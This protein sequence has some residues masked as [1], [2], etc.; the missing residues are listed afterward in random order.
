MKNSQQ[1]SRWKRSKAYAA[2][3]PKEPPES[4]S[5]KYPP[6]SST[7][8][9]SQGNRNEIN[10]ERDAGVPR[11]SV[12]ER[13]QT[14]HQLPQIQIRQQDQPQPADE[15][16]DIGM[17]DEGFVSNTT[18]FISEVSASPAPDRS[19]Q[20][21]MRPVPL[22]ELAENQQE[23]G[24]L[25]QDQGEYRPNTYQPPAREEHSINVVVLSSQNHPPGDPRQDIPRSLVPGSGGFSEKKH[26][27]PRSHD[28]PHALP[29]P[30]PDNGQPGAWKQGAEKQGDDS[31]N[32]S[33]DT[34][35]QNHH[36]KRNEWQGANKEASD[37]YLYAG[38][39]GPRLL[40]LD[41]AHTQNTLAIRTV[42]QSESHSTA[43]GSE[44]APK[45]KVLS[46]LSR[47]SDAPA[48]KVTEGYHK[49]VGRRSSNPGA[50]KPM[51]PKP[52]PEAHPALPTHAE[53]TLR[54]I[55]TRI[56]ELLRQRA[57]RIL[58]KIPPRGPVIETFLDWVP[59]ELDVWKTDISSLHGKITVLE[60][61]VRTATQT[62]RD[63][64]DNARKA[65]AE[66][67]QWKSRYDATARDAD[68]LRTRLNKEENNSAHVRQELHKVNGEVTRL[69]GS[70]QEIESANW[71]LRSEI[72]QT[73]K[74]LHEQR[75]TVQ[76]L[77]KQLQEADTTYKND[78]ALLNEEL[79]L[80]KE[81]RETDRQAHS[82]QLASQRSDFQQ[83][84][85][86]EEKKHK[87]IVRK[88]RQVIA[89][90]DVENY[91]PI[92]DDTFQLSFQTIAQTIGNLLVLVPQ[93]SNPGNGAA[94]EID[95]TGFLARRMSVR[96][97][98]D[99]RPR[100]G[101]VQAWPR[102][103]R[104]VCWR[105][106]VEGF[107]QDQPGFGVFGPEGEGYELLKGLREVFMQTT[108][109]GKMSLSWP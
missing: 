41:A 6:R 42:T 35:C 12:D 30:H 28:D 65:E 58:P 105:I 3:V 91:R 63:E 24:H 89:S 15:R 37:P 82:E 94:A 77:N 64:G 44:Q 14:Q 52:E 48:Q 103:F 104:S 67:N 25:P 26:P 61:K 20:V 4:V 102:F 107:F 39:A 79:D 17:H 40:G 97:N 19:A 33:P 16:Q 49:L 22:Q 36:G 29:R 75:A 13:R 96:L 76:W 27:P 74:S 43:F 53:V 95:S 85:E 108:A 87:Q 100:G 18:G 56:Y 101:G 8:A 99:S 60:G 2:N 93:P 70:F 1:S 10:T 59:R 21:A 109:D 66:R 69:N 90:H 55:E 80:E 88:Q 81:S 31:Q 47:I 106:L 34:A 9:S 51:Q 98:G 86:Q 83:Q 38:A 7:S 84:K 57:N 54:D 45:Q 32:R 73:T 78:L 72:H 23:N 62:A 11:Q 5:S 68:E 46:K 71:G 92:G 50:L